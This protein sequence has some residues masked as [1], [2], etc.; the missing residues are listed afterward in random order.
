MYQVLGLTSYSHWPEA[1]KLRE[2]ARL[3]GQI[4]HQLQQLT[5]ARVRAMLHVGVMEEL[6]LSIAS[7]AVS[8]CASSCIISHVVQHA[9]TAWFTAASET[10][11]MLARPPWASSWMD[12][13]G[14]RRHPMP[15]PMR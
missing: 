12:Q 7:L 14:G 6:P 11:G 8:L 1:A 13:R 15:S 2:C 10:N 5:E 3:H 9:I 4:Q